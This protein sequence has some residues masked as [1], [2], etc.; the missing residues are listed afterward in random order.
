VP[1]KI[2]ILG[3]GC[4]NCARLA[5]LTERIAAE[6]GI[7]CEIEKVSDIV[8]ITRFGV[9]SPPGLVVDGT[10]L[11]SGRVPSADEIRRMLM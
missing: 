5:D 10:V 4:P 6:L 11:V 9:L 7:D 8:E 3:P 2:Q 1:K